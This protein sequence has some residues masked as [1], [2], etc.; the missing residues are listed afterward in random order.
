LY[1][2]NGSVKAIYIAASIMQLICKLLLWLLLLKKLNMLTLHII[3]HHSNALFLINVTLALNVAPL[4]LKQLA[5]MFLLETYDTLL[6]SVA[7][8]ATALQLDVFLLLMKFVNL[9]TSSE[10][11]V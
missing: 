10:T 8:G 7:P 6:C 3:H 4:F 11:Q 2:N 5:F 9:Q 1:E